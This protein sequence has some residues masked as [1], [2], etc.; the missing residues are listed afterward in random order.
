[1]A[2]TSQTLGTGPTEQVDLERLRAGDEETFIKLVARHHDAMVRVARSF[3]PS[4]AVAEEVV[5]DSWLAVLRGL[6]RFEGRSSFQTW[7]Y[8]IL[9]NRARSTGVR[10]HHHQVPIGDHDRSVGPSR[11]DGDGRWSLPPEHWADDLD[12]RLHAGE[13]SSSIWSALDGLPAQQRNVVALRDVEGLDSTE[14]C[15]L[16]DITA[17]NQR[18]L[19]HRGRSRMREALEI[20]FGKV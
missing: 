6:D 1:M 10:E 4:H 15:G 16:L 20:E 8:R 2:K 14:V 12:E 7:L 19:L 11:F 17:A 13:L 5:Q 9:I 18:V 3:V